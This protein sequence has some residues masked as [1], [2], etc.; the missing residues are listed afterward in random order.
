M[1]QWRISA[2][3][4]PVDFCSKLRKKKISITKKEKYS[5]FNIDKPPKPKKIRSKFR[6]EET[7]KKIAK[8]IIDL[9]GIKCI[10]IDPNGTRYEFNTIKECESK[11]NY[12]NLTPNAV[13]IFPIDGSLK[14]GKRGRWKGW[15]FFRII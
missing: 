14:V 5:I 8:T 15:T 12:K 9:Q 13:N 6:T 4:I 3:R 7:K 1:P 10:V 2:F 11:L